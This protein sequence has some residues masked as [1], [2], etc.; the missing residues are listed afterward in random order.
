MYPVAASHSPIPDHPSPKGW[1]PCSVLPLPLLFAQSSGPAHA[2]ALPSL[3]LL[4]GRR[5]SEACFLSTQVTP[6][7]TESRDSS[8]SCPFHLPSSGKGRGMYGRSPL[9]LV[10]RKGHPQLGGKA[11]NK[12]RGT[13]PNSPVWLATSASEKFWGFCRMRKVSAGPTTLPGR[14]G[15]TV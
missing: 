1:N 5:W 11:R 9:S 6:P 2:P 10:P 13:L 4:T 3:A 7:E 8:N 14:G 12:I 15:V